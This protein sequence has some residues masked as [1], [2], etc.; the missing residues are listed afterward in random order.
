MPRF[1]SRLVLR[2][3]GIF[4]LLGV[5]LA[6]VAAYFSISLFKN[7][8]TD[9]K[10]LLPTQARSVVDLKEISGRLESIDNLAV[11][12]F[13][14][15]PEQSEKFVVDLAQ[16][17]EGYPKSVISS[18]EYRIDRELK[19]FKDRQAIYTDIADLNKIKDY[20]QR[21]IQY[22]RDLYNPLNIFSSKELPEPIL[23]FYGMKKKYESKT[24]A[25]ERFPKGFY[26]TPDG[27]IRAVLVYL[28][29]DSGID[30]IKE[31]KAAVDKSISELNPKSYAPDLE[32]KFTNGVQ[33]TF[34]EHE[35][36]IADLVLSTVIV[37]VIV[38]LAMILFYRSLLAT[39]ALVSSL[40]IGVF[41]TFGLA[42]FAVGY[43]NANSA[44]LGS[45]VI[46]NGIN[47]GIIFLARYLEERRKGNGN[48]RA[49]YRSISQ[50]A[51]PTLTAAL[52]AGLSYGSL[53]L[54]SFRGFSQF[55]VIGL[56]G[57]VLCW[58]S[59]F[60]LLPTFLTLLDRV[61]SLGPKSRKEPRAYLAGAVAYL[62]NRFPKFIWGVALLATLISL[63]TFTRLD[64][65]IIETNLGK[66]RNKES[67][68]HGSAYLS[69]Y[70]DE[71]FQRYLSPV[72]VLPKSRENAVK[73]AAELKSQAEKEGPDSLIAS[74]QTI[75]DFIPKDQPEKIKL[76]REIKKLLPENI[77]QRLGP[78][79]REQVKTLL[80]P[81]S[82]SPVQLTD[83]PKLIVDKF[84]EK[85]GSI[86]KLVLVAPPLTQETW[87]GDKLI[88]FISSIR[89]STDHVEK[90]A[91][92]A[93]GIAL[94]SDMIQAVGTDGPKA[95]AFAFV[96][97]VVLVIVLFRS[98]GT[99]SQI[100]FALIL[101]VVWLSGLILGF[102][103]KINFLNFIALPIT[104][105]IGVDYG[106]NIFQRYRQEGDGN[107]L[108]VIRN[109][110]GAVGLSSFTTIVGYTSLLIAGNQ[111]FVSFG[112]IAVAGEVTCVIA[113]V[114]ALPAFLLLRHRK[115]LKNISEFAS[116]S[117]PV[118]ATNS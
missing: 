59:T 4:A 40:F 28:P 32:I 36:L 45:I 47:F 43:L 76:L 48:P 73:I 21:R 29:G 118:P 20:I 104:F 83:L 50:T 12:V 27:K 82:F 19:F 77:V 79:D 94:T 42:F 18:V 35:A 64:S 6:G 37:T 23:D 84:T 75:D 38:T 115:R 109:T 13:S 17:L 16:K 81:L 11:L 44:F 8:R 68:E 25:Y 91:A 108:K 72:V 60:T 15:H 107:I 93:G 85:D 63:A 110:G 39:F 88:S 56:M 113:A 2:Y 103:F 101:G 67:I 89:T 105:G 52:A 7:L 97:V 66:L 31:L 80:N 96:A 70:L 57:M 114:V 22:E 111:G 71:I 51:T 86:G 53:M 26:A 87:R 34:E 30:Q 116:K 46:G 69:K 10:E 33:D 54:T 78:N 117:T 14:G 99:I 5:L 102:G 61:R 112:R 9:F 49:I 92:V 95:T 41:W 58:I 65:G 90:G 1:Y 62:V 74:V 106:V 100:L 55:G 24:S 3:A 98:V